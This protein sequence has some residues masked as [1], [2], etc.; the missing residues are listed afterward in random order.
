MTGIVL[1]GVQVIWIASWLLSFLVSLRS[2]S[3][4]SLAPYLSCTSCLS[5]ASS[6]SWS[7]S[8]LS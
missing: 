2:A 8:L 6:C 4:S 5:M 1:Q 7:L 3:L